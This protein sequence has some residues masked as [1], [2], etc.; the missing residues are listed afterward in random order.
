MILVTTDTGQ[1][2]VGD[3]ILPGVFESLEITGTVQTDEA[4]I[5]GKK[6]RVT[7]AVGYTNTR[8]RLSLVL[9]PKNDGGDCSQQIRTIQQLFRKSPSQ[10]V[11]GVYRIVNKHAQSRN[12]NEIIFSEFRTYED[13]RN[14]KII[15]SLEF[16]EHVPV[17]VK[18]ATSGGSGGKGKSAPASGSKNKNKNKKPKESQSNKK[19]AKTP[20]KDTRE[21]GFGKKLIN[22]L[23]GKDNLG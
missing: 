16:I 15:V 19:T 21:P 20:A 2:K 14:E 23:R 6:S 12:I 1:C 10:E 11:P 18:I 8:L 5:K 9:I 22:W 17:N 7:Q 13:N 3:T 4:E